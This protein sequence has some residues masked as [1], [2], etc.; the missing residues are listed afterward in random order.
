VSDH[1][2]SREHR[3]RPTPS[4]GATVNV[5]KGPIHWPTLSPLDAEREWPA[6]RAWVDDLRER[7][8]EDLDHHAIPSSCWFSHESHV[9]ALQ[10]LRDHERIAYDPNSPTSS[11]VDWHRAYRDIVALL[12]DMTSH[13]R[14]TPTE[15]FRART[16]PAIDEVAYGDFVAEDIAR[17]RR[18]AIDRALGDREVGYGR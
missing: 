3:G 4:R 9:V 6:L 2:S 17:R 8:P 15:H 5:A 1:P 7:Y 11:A 14:C 13:L 16:I 12:R 18:E 10:A